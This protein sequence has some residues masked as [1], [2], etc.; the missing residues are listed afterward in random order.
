[1]ESFSAENVEHRLIYSAW[2][3]SHRAIDCGELS[4]QQEDAESNRAIGR[5]LLLLLL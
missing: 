3:L 2:A 5:P 1:M 4:E